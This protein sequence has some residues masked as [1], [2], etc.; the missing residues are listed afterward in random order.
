MTKWSESF[1]NDGNSYPKKYLMHINNPD[2]T[3][4]ANSIVLSPR[5]TAT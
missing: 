3:T 1:Q 2:V 5:V 4:N